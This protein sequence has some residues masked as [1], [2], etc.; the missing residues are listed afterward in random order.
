M[1]IEHRKLSNFVLGIGSHFALPF[2]RNR[3]GPRSFLLVFAY[4]CW[5]T[6]T[7]HLILWNIL[8]TP[9]CR[10][11]PFRFAVGYWGF[12]C[13]LDGCRVPRLCPAA[14][15]VVMGTFGFRRSSFL[16]GCVLRVVVIALGIGKTLHLSSRRPSNLKILDLLPFCNGMK[17]SRQ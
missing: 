16:L 6:V 8:K 17:S 4:C 12:L 10:I 1:T 11:V 5:F 14:D 7:S 3:L 13:L 2:S 9:G 15:S